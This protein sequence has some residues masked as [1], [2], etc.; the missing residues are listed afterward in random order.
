MAA[1]IKTNRYRRTRRKP[2]PFCVDKAEFI[3]YKGYQRL[4]RFVTDRGKIKPRK[5]E[6][7]CARHQR[8]LAEAIKRARQVALLPYVAE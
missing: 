5:T 4:R 6:G 1:R 8:M 7:V 3:D 2:C